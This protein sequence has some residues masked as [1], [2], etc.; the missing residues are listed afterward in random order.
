LPRHQS[1]RRSA[2]AAVLPTSMAAFMAAAVLRTQG[3]VAVVE[4][5]EVGA[6][7]PSPDSPEAGVRLLVAPEDE[8][9]ALEVLRDRHLI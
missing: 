9:R 6:A 7:P 2:T 1:D 3:I 5:P 4:S 8:A